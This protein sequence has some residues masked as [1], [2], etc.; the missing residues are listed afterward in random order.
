MLDVVE[1]ELREV[2]REIHTFEPLER[3]RIVDVQPVLR[4]DNY[5]P[6]VL[7]LIEGA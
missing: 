2:T 3:D 5:V 7:Q 4:P 1:P 6:V